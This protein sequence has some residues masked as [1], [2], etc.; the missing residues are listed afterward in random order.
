MA[1]ILYKQ[2]HGDELL[3]IDTVNNK[4]ENIYERRFNQRIYGSFIVVQEDGVFI[5]DKN[6]KY[7]VAVGDC[8]FLNYDSATVIRS[9]ELSKIVLEQ[10]DKINAKDAEC[11]LQ[12]ARTPCADK[13]L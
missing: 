7:E 8:I 12:E 3:L 9:E 5:D 10:I 13:S 6:N 11:S 1:N 4:V 2:F